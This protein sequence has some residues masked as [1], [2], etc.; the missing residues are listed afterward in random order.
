[1]IFKRFTILLVVRL[2]L[3]GADFKKHR[4]AVRSAGF[5]DDL[6]GGMAR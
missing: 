3:V 6:P 5:L 2:S 1:M 4:L